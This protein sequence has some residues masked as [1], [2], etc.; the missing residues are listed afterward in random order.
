MEI[1][2]VVRES[3]K[4]ISL[5]RITTSNYANRKIKK[6]RRIYIFSGS[7]S[8]EKI[9]TKQDLVFYNKILSYFPQEICHICED[10]VGYQDQGRCG[11]CASKYTYLGNQRQRTCNRTYSHAKK[12]PF[13]SSRHRRQ[14]TTSWVLEAFKTT[15]DAFNKSHDDFQMIIDYTSEQLGP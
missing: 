12:I 2:S 8:L 14:D 9:E 13:P 4:K 7:E 5:V 6:L 11:T 1:T 3:D 10:G 15:F